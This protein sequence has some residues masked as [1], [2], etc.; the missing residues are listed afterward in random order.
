MYYIEGLH[1]KYDACE[2]Q[3]NRLQ[4]EILTIKENYN[5][6]ESKATKYDDAIQQLDARK[7]ETNSLKDELHTYKSRTVEVE[8]DKVEIEK[9]CKFIGTGGQ[10][11]RVISSNHHKFL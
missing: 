7:F 9:K 8:K 3:R 2:N 10:R 11:N 1:R 4:K 6:Y 5:V